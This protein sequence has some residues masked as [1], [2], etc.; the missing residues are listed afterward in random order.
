MRG[1]FLAL[2]LTGLF[3]LGLS[4]CTITDLSYAQSQTNQ[5][6]YEFMDRRGEL[7][8]VRRDNDLYVENLEGGESRRVTFTPN[9]KEEG[10]FSK[11]GRYIVYLTSGPDAKRYEAGAHGYRADF[12][13]EKFYFQPIDGD[14]KEKT[15]ITFME[16]LDLWISER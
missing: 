13:A 15:E 7:R 6:D 1:M 8:L 2:I 16:F 4:E 14:D 3:I 12:Y 11:D 9:V 10:K 5:T